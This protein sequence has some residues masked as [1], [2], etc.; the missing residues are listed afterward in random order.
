MQR[1]PCSR[2]GDVA[3]E[4]QNCHCGHSSGTTAIQPQCANSDF[5]LFMFP[6]FLLYMLASLESLERKKKNRAVLDC[7]KSQ[8]KQ[9]IKLE[10]WEYAAIAKPDCLEVH[11][12]SHDRALF[13]GFSLQELSRYGD[14]ELSFYILSVLFPDSHGFFIV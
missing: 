5:V 3:R 12:Y 6:S 4:S 2:S 9:R 14:F 13:V 7:S 1:E 8:P 10:F 11:F